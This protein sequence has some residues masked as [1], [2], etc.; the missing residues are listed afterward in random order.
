MD[1]QCFDV[2]DPAEV[3]EWE[4]KSE[5]QSVIRRMPPSPFRS[6]LFQLPLES[7]WAIPVTA[8][9][10]SSFTEGNQLLI[11]HLTQALAQF[12]Q[13]LFVGF[14]CDGHLPVSSGRGGDLILLL[15]RYE[16]NYE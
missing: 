8:Q 1:S 7:V 2:P 14:E 3:P 9:T 6:R 5:S 16:I 13:L 12:L 4:D 11:G 10:P 15:G